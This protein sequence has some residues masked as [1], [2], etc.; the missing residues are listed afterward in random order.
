M[1]GGSRRF[2]CGEALR[3]DWV[4]FKPADLKRLLESMDLSEEFTAHEILNLGQNNET[5]TVL[6]FDQFCQRWQMTPEK[7]WFSL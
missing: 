6:R 1:P 3:E 7:P 2:S 4:G 5:P